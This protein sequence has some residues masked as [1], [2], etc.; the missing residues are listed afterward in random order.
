MGIKLINGENTL[1]G[2]GLRHDEQIAPGGGAIQMG[3]RTLPNPCYNIYFGL[4]VCCAWPSHCRKKKNPVKKDL[5]GG[6]EEKTDESGKRVQQLKIEAPAFTE[7][8]QYGYV[9]PDKYRCDSCRAVLFHLDQE[10]RKKQP[11]GRRMKEWEYNDLFENICR[12]SFE[13]YG[14]VFEKVG[15]TEIYDRF[16]KKFRNEANGVEGED[17]LGLSETLCIHELHDC[18]VGP[19]LPPK[20][21]EKNAEE[22]SEK[23]KPKKAAANKEKSTK[24]KMKSDVNAKKKSRE[25]RDTNSAT[26]TAMQSETQNRGSTSR[27]SDTDVLHVDVQSFLRSLAI[28]HGFSSDEYLAT[29]TVGEWERLT[30]AMA[31]RIFNQFA[32]DE[33]TG[34][35]H[36]QK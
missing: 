11:K 5:A 20:P 36:A 35:C 19:H 17:E 21:T 27:I 6:W 28:R 24:T 18:K 3:G 33:H 1:S 4:G 29:R 22:K 26:S 14:I 12:S 32:N 7:E 34:S 31:S 9:M 13:G 16:Y 2:P 23:V 15:E 25:V 10:L 30:V 8:D